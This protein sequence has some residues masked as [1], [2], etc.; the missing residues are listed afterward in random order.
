MN[1]AFFADVDTGDNALDFTVLA[2]P[3][4]GSAPVSVPEPL[5]G[6]LAITAL[7][8]IGAMGRRPSPEG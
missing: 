2:T 7:A 8:G 6:L 1:F 3:T 5:T 4:P